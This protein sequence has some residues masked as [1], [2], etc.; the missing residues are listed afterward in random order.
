MDAFVGPARSYEHWLAQYRRVWRGTVGTSLLNPVFFLAAMGLGLG[1]LVDASPNAPA[2]VRYVDFV[3]PGLLAA[4]AMQTAATESTFP[5]MA[6]MRWNR[7]YHAMLATPLAVR[8]ILLGHQLF[9][10]TR[11]LLASAAYLAVIAAFGAVDS[12]L[13]LLV[14]PVA[15]LLGLAFAGPIMALAATVENGAAFPPLFRFAIVP[16][17]LFSG[18]FFPV[19]RL[20]LVAEWVAW[21]T[22]LWHGVELSRA[23]TLGDVEPGH[24]AVHVGYLA[25]WA[26][27][28]AALARWR[29]RKALLG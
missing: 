23:L 20:P 26:I 24:A 1:T 8:D 10:A 14:V 25:A 12:P 6:A 16:M 2:G 13:G 9:V 17:F 27:G 3:A 18:T 19:E 7:T 15:V 22:P 4:A 28:G 29:Y 5:V 11:V 21:A